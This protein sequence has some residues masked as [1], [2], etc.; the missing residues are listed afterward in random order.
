MLACILALSHAG[1]VADQS[2]PL[3]TAGHFK[4][5]EAFPYPQRELVGESGRFKL[6]KLGKKDL[7]LLAAEKLRAQLRESLFATNE[8]LFES[9]QTPVWCWAAVVSNA[10]S[11]MGYKISQAQVVQ[12]TYEQVF[13]TT[14]SPYALLNTFGR[15]WTNESGGVFNAHMRAYY[16]ATNP[17]PSLTPGRPSMGI[18]ERTTDL[19]AWIIQS[20]IR[21][22][23]SGA[24]LFDKTHAYNVVALD[25]W[26]ETAPDGQLFEESLPGFS[27]FGEGAQDLKIQSK[28]RTIYKSLYLFDPWPGRG[29][30]QIEC[31]ESNP[32]ARL[33][34]EGG[35][36]SFLARI[37]KRP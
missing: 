3:P 23:D 13:P 7:E 25:F 35:N 9:Q 22:E 5:V 19:Y 26:E 11:Q 8:R 37:M 18:I 21:R 20:L 34:T 24:I 30:I 29:L 2:F 4:R 15:S 36:V 12:H 1:D 6:Y 32:S 10:F 28:V 31:V 33:V 16:D 27:G 17:Q 14:G